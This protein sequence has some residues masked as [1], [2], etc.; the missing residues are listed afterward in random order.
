MRARQDMSGVSKIRPKSAKDGR[1]AT[2]PPQNA[3]AVPKKNRD[4]PTLASL[5]IAA[6]A[7]KIE[8]YPPEALGMLSET[9]WEAIV[10][11]RHSKTAPRQQHQRQFLGIDGKGRM[12]P[13]IGDKVMK[14]IEDANPHLAQ[15][16][17][18]DKL[19]WKDCVNSRFKA[20]GPSRPLALSFPWPVLVKRLKTSG[21][22]L[23]GLLQIPKLDT[24]DADEKY[25]EN[26]CQQRFQVLNR[27]ISIMSE[28]PMS[29]ALLTASGV[30]KS[31]SK[32]IKGCSKSA[33]SRCD[34]APPQ[35]FVDVWTA[36]PVPTV[37]NVPSSSKTGPVELSP[38]T[39]LEMLLQGWKQVAS[40]DGVQVAKKGGS[41]PIRSA[42]DCSGRG[43]KTSEEQHREDMQTLQSCSSW[44]ELHAALVLR[45]AKMVASHG[46]R[47]RQIREN[48]QT[49]RP[50]IGRVTHR[51]AGRR[52]RRE[53]IL[54]GSRGMRA[55]ATASR[56]T[57]SSTCGSSKLQQLRKES[58]IATSR[59]KAGLNKVTKSSFG[60]SIANATSSSRTAAK[61]SATVKPK[62]VALGGGK[63]M[64][65]P[66][67]ASARNGVVAAM[68][69]KQRANLRNP[70]FG[71]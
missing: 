6:V 17:I 14:S 5:C 41:A 51:N 20:G 42:S 21:A 18:A 57:S 4:P 31:V 39:Q 32:F 3:C 69:Q 45:E 1:K 25:V 59:Q 54:D 48:L 2:A 67:N 30:G 23:L 66:Q 10:R 22:D 34:D 13:A 35:F 60:F 40:A 44:R 16:E 63:R 8:R 36:R 52:A 70:S 26:I 33:G 49:D 7:S 19:V 43:K 37:P 65:V 71:R 28:S 58:A 55:L 46:A 24:S 12:M 27:C 68:K 56:A 50:K 9:E 29:V 11:L 62:E 47:M 38:L 61:R 15:S 64:K 53:A